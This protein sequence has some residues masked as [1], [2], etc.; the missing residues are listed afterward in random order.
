MKKDDG[1]C[2]LSAMIAATDD[3][4]RGCSWSALCITIRD[5]QA[6][7]LQLEDAI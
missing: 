6:R 4:D 1:F 3:C 7:V 2:Y 5:L